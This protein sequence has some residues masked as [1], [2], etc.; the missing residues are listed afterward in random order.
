MRNSCTM[1][2]SK[3]AAIA[4]QW[5]VNKDLILPVTAYILVGLAL[6]SVWPAERGQRWRHRLFNLAYLCLYLGF[7]VTVGEA[8]LAWL[9]SP[10][11]WFPTLSIG[12][13][14]SLPGAVMQTLVYMLIYDFFY[15]WWHRAQHRFSWLWAI[16][17][18]HHSERSLNVTAAF[19]HHWLEDVLKPWIV[20]L[21]ISWLFQFQSHTFAAVGI[22]F[23]AW[24]FFIHLNVRLPLGPTGR[25]LVG[26]QYHR[27]HHSIELKH[28]D[29]NFAAFF[30]PWDMFFG[31]QH[32]PSPNE[33]PATGVTGQSG[34]PLESLREAVVSPFRQWWRAF[35]T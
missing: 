15:Y 10:P 30:A 12:L 24:P 20:L 7:T 9:P 34:E 26:P 14:S 31:T 35:R 1:I 21:P 19:R 32:Q 33:F 5:P 11:A 4:T 3:L 16:H 2:L 6:E 17:Q 13:A 28:H 25:V 27:V 8:L 29:R 18:L 23:I 22:A